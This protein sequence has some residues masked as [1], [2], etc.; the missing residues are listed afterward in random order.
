MPILAELYYHAYQPQDFTRIPVVLIHGAG[1]NHL[2][3]PPEVRRLRSARCYALD[4][5][6]H[7][8][9]PGSSYQRIEDYADHLLRWLNEA[10]IYRAVF[11]GH[12]MG[13]AIAMSFALR[14]PERVLGL[15]IV[16][17][18]ARLRVAPQILEYT[19]HP[20]TFPKAVTLITEWAFSKNAE[21]RLVKLASQR[22]A[23]IRPSVLHNDMLACNAFDILEQV[24][25]ISQPA[26]IICGEEDR[27]TPLR[28]SM[29]LSETMPDAELVIVPDAGHM[30]MLEKPLVVADALTRF[31]A[32][33]PYR[34]G[35]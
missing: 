17:S 15:G 1:G 4:L 28:F 6:A 10:K 19:A 32:R 9:S 11:V 24:N 29:F 7:G 21:K 31:L 34:P 16:G 18:A 13:G 22:M 23:E 25:E 8:K 27:L 20:M 30:V 12:S 35:E 2:Y 3:W 14:Y 26:L 33:I 5:P